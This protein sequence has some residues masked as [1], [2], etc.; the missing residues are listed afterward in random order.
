MITAT[1]F[2]ILFGTLSIFLLEYHHGLSKLS[3][4]D[5]LLTSYFQ[6]VST[7]TAGFNTIE[8]NHLLPATYAVMIFLMFIGAAPVSSAGGIKVTTFILI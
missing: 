6:S 4:K 3:I 5:K 1:A 7:R 8:L 2:L